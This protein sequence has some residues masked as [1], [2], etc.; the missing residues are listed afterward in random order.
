MDFTANGYIQIL[1]VSI[2][3]RLTTLANSCSG[4]KVISS[5]ESMQQP[6]KLGNK[7]H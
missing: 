3:R 2:R 4:N 6:P 7:S 1:S 5:S